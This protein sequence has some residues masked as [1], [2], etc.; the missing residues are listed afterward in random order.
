MDNLKILITGAS[1]LLGLYLIKQ[2]PQDSEIRGT[3]FGEYELQDS[4]KVI[5][6]KFNLLESNLEEIIL[7]DFTPNVIIH[8]ASIGNVDYCESHPNEA[9]ALNLDATVKLIEIAEKYNAH[10]IF[11]SSNAVYDGNNAPY[12]RG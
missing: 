8:T 6:R 5:F 12:K 4:D 3:Y 7:D 10:F 9:R 11:T 1:G 2:K